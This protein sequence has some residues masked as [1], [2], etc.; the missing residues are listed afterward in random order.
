MIILMGLF[1]KVAGLWA[2]AEMQH[3]AD[4]KAMST[5]LSHMLQPQSSLMLAAF[6]TCAHLSISAF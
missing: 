6:M 1:G 4:A 3:T 2:C 5:G